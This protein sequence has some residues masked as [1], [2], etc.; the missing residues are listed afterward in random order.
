MAPTEEQID[1]F[2]L[3][4]RYGELDEVK[5]FVE[6]FGKEVVDQIKDDR[7]NTA[8]HMV[9]GNGHLGESLFSS[10]DVSTDDAD[11]LEYLLP[12]VSAPLLSQVNDNGSPP[13]H[14][15]ILNN[16]VSCVKALVEVPEEKGGGLPIL[17]V[18][19][20]QCLLVIRV[21]KANIAAKERSR[22]TGSLR[23]Y[24][25]WRGQ[26]GS[27]RLDRGISL[28]SRGWRGGRGNEEVRGRWRGGQGLRRR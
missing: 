7:G 5:A 23:S 18:G 3:S 8:L 9:C 6:E 17:K 16:H 15:A 4:C 14:W 19:P 27:R 10:R 13:A 26:R 24:L 12:L 2:L 22:T 21:L 20:T 1:E 25:R 28:A 11:V